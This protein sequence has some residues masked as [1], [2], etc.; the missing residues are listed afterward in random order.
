MGRVF[1]ST[2]AFIDLIKSS[3]YIYPC[4]TAIEGCYLYELEDV[5]GSVRSY[6][7]YAHIQE[8]GENVRKFEPVMGRMVNDIPHAKRFD[9]EGLNHY[10][11]VFQPHPKRD[12]AI[13]DFFES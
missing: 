5:E 3:S 6:I 13:L 7:D 12:R 8:A 11:V 4:S 10:G 2:E 1:L 9:V